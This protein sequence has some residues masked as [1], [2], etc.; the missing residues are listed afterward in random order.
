MSQT[1]D[2]VR[3]TAE[4]R[5]FNDSDPYLYPG[6]DHEQAQH[7]GI[8]FKLP[9]WCNI[10]ASDK[11]YRPPTNGNVPAVYFPA[12]QYITT[13]AGLEVTAVWDL[14]PVNSVPSNWG[15]IGPH[16]APVIY[17]GDSDTCN[18]DDVETTPAPSATTQGSN[19]GASTGSSSD[20]NDKIVIILGVFLAAAIV[21]VLIVAVLQLRKRL[22]I[23][24]DHVKMTETV[25]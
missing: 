4:Q 24:I 12:T 1:V 20:K 6:L 18:C 10:P 25:G 9:C 8:S 17:M 13:K 14:I 3:W 2:V 16:P 15:K 11:L 21:L 22:P 5:H 23:T 7:F 19:T